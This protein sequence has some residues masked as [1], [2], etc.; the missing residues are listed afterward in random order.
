MNF[1]YNIKEIVH[2]YCSVNSGI[3]IQTIWLIGF[4]TLRKTYLLC[5]WNVL[6]YVYI[7]Y[8]CQRPRNSV[9]GYHFKWLYFNS[10]WCIRLLVSEQQ[11]AIEISGAYPFPISV[12]SSPDV[13]QCDSIWAHVD[14]SYYLYFKTKSRRFETLGRGTCIIIADCQI[15]AIY[16]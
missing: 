8:I 7:Q 11:I 13:A 10:V 5:L 16:C 15:L 12:F 1:I 14:S 6:V 9:C 4:N 2:V 3:N